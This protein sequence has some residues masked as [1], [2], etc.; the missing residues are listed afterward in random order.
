MNTSSNNLQDINANIAIESIVAIP[1]E[2]WSLDY[3]QPKP[4]CVSKDGKCIDS[5]YPTPPDSKKIKFESDE[6]AVSINNISYVNLNPKESMIDIKAKVQSP[7][8]YIFIVQY[9][10]PNFPGICLLK[11]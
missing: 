10:Q 5:T 9:Y 8:Y 11:H 7:G 2:K 6:F 1:L 4:L 3:I